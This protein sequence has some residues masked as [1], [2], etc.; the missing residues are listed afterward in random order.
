MKIYQNDV[1][2][3]NSFFSQISVFFLPVD[4]KKKN[5]QQKACFKLLIQILIKKGW[6]KVG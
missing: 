6:P 3:S 1:L 4:K 2:M 5:S